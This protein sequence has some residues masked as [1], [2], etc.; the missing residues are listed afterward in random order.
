M[1]TPR[2]RLR[3]VE[4]IDDISKIYAQTHTHVHTCTHANTPSWSWNGPR[5][6]VSNERWGDLRML[7]VAWS[8]ELGIVS[9]RRRTGR[10]PMYVHS[11]RVQWKYKTY[12]NVIGTKEK[13]AQGERKKLR[14]ICQNSFPALQTRPY[15]T[16]KQKVSFPS[17]SCSPLSS[18]LGKA[19]GLRGVI[20]NAM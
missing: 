6:W 16:K 10:P 18:L 3:G 20:G 14:W 4:T 13:K 7:H 1:E 9:R 12:R 5:I 2:P 17:R 19:R 8:R 15:R 11:R